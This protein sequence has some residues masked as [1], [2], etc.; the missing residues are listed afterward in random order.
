MMDDA[1]RIKFENI[2]LRN[3]NRMLRSMLCKA[4]KMDEDTLQRFI[5]V[6]SD[7]NNR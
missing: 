1:D 6:R 4:M 5:N 7:G 3:E 2:E